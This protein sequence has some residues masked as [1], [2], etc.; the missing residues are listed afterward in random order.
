MDARKVRSNV[1][2]GLDTFADFAVFVLS[3]TS[4]TFVVCIHL[5]VFTP[6]F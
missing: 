6:D 2:F 3:G 4:I 5:S 1:I